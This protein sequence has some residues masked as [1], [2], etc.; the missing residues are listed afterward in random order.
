MTEGECTY[1]CR[2]WYCVMT[3]GECIYECRQWDCV[4]LMAVEG[5]SALDCGFSGRKGRYDDG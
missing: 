3:E 4:M 5:I 1:E 2:Q